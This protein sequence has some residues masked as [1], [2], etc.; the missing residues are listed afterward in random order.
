MDTITD[1]ETD[2]ETDMAGAN[3]WCPSGQGKSK[4]WVTYLG[5][6][7]SQYQFVLAHRAM[8]LGFEM[9]LSYFSGIPVVFMKNDGPLLW[10]TL[11]PAWISNPMPIN[12]WDEITYPFPNFNGCTVKVW[13]WIS[14]F[15]I[16]FIVDVI[17]HPWRDQS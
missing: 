16:H 10:L 6:F 12:V 9:K 11:I 5:T 17:P 1:M 4:L 14:N 15:I 13:E 3:I 2:T 8:F 7:W